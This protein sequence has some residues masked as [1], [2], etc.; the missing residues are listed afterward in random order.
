MKKGIFVL[1]I[2]NL[3]ASFSLIKVS[4]CKKL[5]LNSFLTGVAYYPLTGPIN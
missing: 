3:M 1:L 2:T 5:L 4:M